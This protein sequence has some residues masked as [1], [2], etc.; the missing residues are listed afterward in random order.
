MATRVLKAWELSTP[1]EGMVMA[2][3]YH[4]IRKNGTR[5][6]QDWLESYILE[7]WWRTA[8]MNTVCLKMLGMSPVA[9]AKAPVGISEAIPHRH[10][11]G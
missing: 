5:R 3:P 8:D 2:W 4:E 11:A 9:Y 7:S 6:I 10:K 1:L